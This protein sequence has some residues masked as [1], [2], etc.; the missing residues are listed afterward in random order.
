LTH[1]R[2]IKK[3]PTDSIKSRN[4]K[5]EEAIKLN[6]RNLQK[7]DRIITKREGGKGLEEPID[8]RD[9]IRGQRNRL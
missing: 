2:N 1:Y 4:I 8:S 6:S 5:I 3:F 9:E 7:T